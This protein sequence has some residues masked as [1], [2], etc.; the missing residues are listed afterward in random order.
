MHSCAMI[1]PVSIGL[2]KE[3]RKR[4]GYSV[5]GKSAKMK[6]SP[7]RRRGPTRLSSRRERQVCFAITRTVIPS[8]FHRERSGKQE[9]NSQM[10][11]CTFGEASKMGSTVVMVCLRWPRGLKHLQSTPVQRPFARHLSC[12]LIASCKQVS[13]I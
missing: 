9:T 11:R 1:S 13:G 5:L 10:R 2:Y 7:I 3:T 4:A 6:K 8:R 12:A